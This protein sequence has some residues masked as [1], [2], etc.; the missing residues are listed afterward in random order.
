MPVH[1]VIFIYSNDGTTVLESVSAAQGSIT[2]QET[3][4]SAALG[5]YEYGGDKKFL[6]FATSANATEPTYAIGD[7]FTVSSD[8]TLYI[9]ESEVTDL[10]NTAWYFCTTK[11]DGAEAF[12][13]NGIL[14]VGNIEYEITGLAC[15]FSLGRIS[16]YNGDTIVY[17]QYDAEYVTLI[18][19]D[20]ADVANS[21]LI[22]YLETNGIQLKVTDLTNTTW[23][24]PAGW[25]AE[26]EYGQFYIDN[27]V[28]SDVRSSFY[29]GHGFD[30]DYVEIISIANSIYTPTV[31]TSSIAL[32]ISIT[33]GT[34]VTN[35][36][37]IAWL[38]QYG[39]LQGEEEEPTDIKPVYLRKNGAWVKQDAYERQNGEWVK[40]SNALSAVEEDLTGTYILNSNWSATAEYSSDH[41]FSI[42]GTL[43]GISFTTLYIGWY[44]DQ[45]FPVA[46][47]N[48]IC[49]VRDRWDNPYY[50]SPTIVTFTIT[51]GIDINNES[52][53]S[54]L[55]AN[56]TK[57]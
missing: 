40:I 57:Q 26:A 33:G 39:E 2:V 45:T 56:T 43:D 13:V 12:H 30:Y 36:K 44:W 55:K 24:V 18:I 25:E 41:G 54:W 29:I 49:F 50:D 3:G 20:G 23:Y 10:T 47:E 8:T 17:T 31:Y 4:F 38:S 27:S 53:R 34:D 14:V 52:L 7:T 5:S 28:N 15:Y 42:D 46:M 16:Y 22:S 35:P 32:T 37:L 11:T 48:R 51:G 21:I 6:G 9:V 1:N 19:D